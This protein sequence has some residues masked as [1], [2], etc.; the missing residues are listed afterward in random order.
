MPLNPMPDDRQNSPP[1]INLIPFQLSLSPTLPTIQG[2]VDYQDFRQ[3][4]L[5]T[6]DLLLTSDLESHLLQKDLQRWLAKRPGISPRAQQNHQLHAQRALRCNLARCLLGEDYRSFAAR[7]A[8]SP[9]LQHFCCI[10]QL[11]MVKVPSKSTLERYDKWWPE[12]ELRALLYQFMGQG[13]AAPHKLDLPEAV[14]LES[15]FLDTTCLK[16]N[17]HYPVDW[18]LL[19]D[20]SRTLLKAVQLIRAQGLKQRMEEPAVFLSRINKLCIEMTHAGKKTDSQRQRKQ[21]LRKID[22]LVGII[23][24]HAQGYRQL[25][26]E[27]WAE[28]K[29]SQAQ[30]R[31]VLRRMDQVL[32]QLPAARAQARQR[33]LRGE[34]V[35]NQ[36][37]ILSLYEADVHV[38]VR[39]KAGAEVEFGNTLFLAENSQG[40]ILDWELFRERAPADSELLG[41][42]VGRMEEVYGPTL[43]EVAADR[44]FDSEANRV[45]LAEDKIYNGVCP[46][47]VQSLKKRSCSWKFKR[48]QRRRGQVEARISIVK[49]VFLKGR[50]RSKGFE[51]RELTV[52]WT[53]LTHNL[54]VLARMQQ[55]A[56]KAEP[57]RLAA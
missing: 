49:N 28:T 29:W 55:R 2:N 17:I 50:P 32:E 4:L 53:V 43:K 9:L 40:L 3:L 5:H 12:S 13:A 1:P 36:E 22:R 46:R 35:P 51:H 39:G 34:Q 26:E 41:Q 30:A 54:W 27:H 37:K 38:L 10:D 23:R 8:D 24:N 25:L 6:R 14:D 31:Q 11:G 48:L 56:K 20:G 18:L 21:T 42:S 16:A 7:L 44:G 52:T 57:E 33:I 15:A 47:S 45:G 19:R